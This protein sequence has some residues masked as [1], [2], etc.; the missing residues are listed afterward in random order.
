MSNY[1]DIKALLVKTLLSGCD[2]FS[3]IEDIFISRDVGAVATPFLT[4]V[5]T[6]FFG[7]MLILCAAC[8][9]VV[10]SRCQSLIGA[11]KLSDNFCGIVENGTKMNTRLCAYKA[12]LTAQFP[13]LCRS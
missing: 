6:V 4:I 2:N 5:L 8:D 11:L 10:F 9:I 12:L 1:F 13:K 7:A 3:S